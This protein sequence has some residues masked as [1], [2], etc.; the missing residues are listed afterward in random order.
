MRAGRSSL[1]VGHF[2]TGGLGEV[3]S[4][5]LKANGGLLLGHAMQGAES[6]DQVT[7]VD[8]DD[9]AVRE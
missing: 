2:E 5:E 3:L 8:A 4:G 7:G 6:P 1:A 9:F